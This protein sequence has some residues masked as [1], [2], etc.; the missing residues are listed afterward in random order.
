MN[1]LTAIAVLEFSTMQKTFLKY[2]NIGDKPATIERFERFIVAK[3]GD[4]PAV[5]N[6]NYYEKESRRFLRQITIKKG[7]YTGLT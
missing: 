6:I 2:R 3:A 1:Y 5:I 4:K 7:H